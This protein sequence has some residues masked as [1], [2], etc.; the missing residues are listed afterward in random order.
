[1]A[2]LFCARRARLSRCGAALQGNTAG[3]HAERQAA[4][5]CPLPLGLALPGCCAACEACLCRVLAI[6]QNFTGIGCMHGAA[7][8]AACPPGARRRCCAAPQSACPWRCALRACHRPSRSRCCRLGTYMQGPASSPDSLCLVSLP[9]RL[10]GPWG[11]LSKVASRRVP[12][13]TAPGCRHR[14]MC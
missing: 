2:I 8:R 4:H 9:A 1:M 7:C 12:C 3:G 13:L 14:V 6:L 11:R 5:R 10:L